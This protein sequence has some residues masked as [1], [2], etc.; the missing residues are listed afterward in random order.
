[1]S[2]IVTKQQSQSSGWSWKH[3]IKYVFVF[4]T[5]PFL[6][7]Y[8]LSIRNLDQMTKALDF[9]L[10]NFLAFRSSESNYRFLHQQPLLNLNNK[11][12]MDINVCYQAFFQ[13]ML[14]GNS[15][16]NFLL[17][18]M[19]Q[20]TIVLHRN[21]QVESCGNS[22]S[23]GRKLT[24]Y[25]WNVLED[26]QNVGQSCPN[27]S[28]KY[29]V[30]AFLTRLIQKLMSPTACQSD[31]GKRQYWDSIGLYGYCDMGVEKTPILLDHKNLLSNTLYDQSNN[32]V[33]FLPCHFHTEQG[34]RVTSLKQFSNLLQN[35]IKIMRQEEQ[36]CIVST[37]GE[38]T[39]PGT[40]DSSF[41]T[42][43]TKGMNGIQPRND[44]VHLYAVPAGRV[45]M[46][47]AAYV[48]QIIELPHVKGA[49]PNQLVFLK[50][51]S[52]SPA[53]FDLYNFFT[54]GESQELVA[55]ALAETKESHR[56]KRSTTG[57]V[58]RQI[59]NRRTSESG[60]DTDGKTAIEIKK[61]VNV[62]HFCR[63]P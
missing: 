7:G 15:N 5:I 13:Q 28:N 30:E 26:L 49:D 59:N 39:C 57:S 44:E 27:F 9:L 63:F 4:I 1:M 33:S 19:D 22:S 25:V 32:P 50:V 23:T 55:R 60:F 34:V 17:E 14:S 12:K 3:V 54:K 24:S 40:A 16:S 61:Y 21:G 36:N 11:S 41:E 45:F 29:H 8:I 53:V 43:A 20:I 2:V 52:V 48:G 42:T 58:G 6:V 10:S 35:Q 46:H 31:D 37:D 51:L 56:I 47:V 18:E 62:S 38:N